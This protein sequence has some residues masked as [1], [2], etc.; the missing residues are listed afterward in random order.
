[1][2]DAN[3]DEVDKCKQIAQSALASGDSAKALRFL[4]KAKRMDPSDASIDDLMAAAQAGGGTASPSPSSETG[5]GASGAASQGPRFRTNAAHAEGPSAAGPS[6]PSAATRTD[7][8]GKSYT[9]EQMG[10]VQRILRTKDYYDIMGVPRD[11]GPDAIKKAYRKGAVKLHPD[12]NC[13]PGAAEAFKKFS[14]AYQCLSD[15]EKRHIYEQYGDEEK[16]PQQHRQHYQQDFMNPEDLFA[17]FFGGGTFHTFHG[18]QHY[19]RGDDDGNQRAHLLQMLPVILLV[20]L[21]LAS[22]FQRDNGSRFSFSPSSNYPIE[23]NTAN[24]FV[25][26]YVTNDF[27][28]HYPEGTRSL[29]EFERQV[30]IYHARDLHSECS[31]QEKVKYKEVIMAKRR[32]SE[33]D[34]AAAKSRPIT[35]CKELD[36]IKRKHTGI[37]RAAMYMGG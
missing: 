10:E 25:N 33:E 4:T 3:R 2:A 35:A 31:Y 6:R 15:K 13:A 34:V 24:L 5:T 18:N 16:M 32:G 37:Y 8:S 30:E 17:S 11:A 20:L 26:Y 27:E 7:K 14:K 9:S 21:T 23:R 36:K 1:M 28:D 12:K 29:A 19:H 22:N